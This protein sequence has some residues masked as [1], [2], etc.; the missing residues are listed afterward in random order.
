MKNFLVKIIGV[1][2]VLITLTAC[3]GGG[4]VNMVKTGTFNDYQG[5]TVGDAFDNW[6]MCENTYWTEFQTENGR[7]IV[8]YEC[9]AKKQSYTGLINIY[10]MSDHGELR[11]TVCFPVVIQG[12][13]CNFTVDRALKVL[14]DGITYRVQ[15][16]VNLDDTF[17]VSY[18]G[19]SSPKVGEIDMA[20]SGLLN[21]EEFLDYVMYN[22]ESLNDTTPG[23]AVDLVS[24]NIAQLGDMELLNL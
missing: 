6:S 21:V 11:D 1:M 19:A 9:E 3:G 23:G 17:E 22:D 24:S 7:N 8:E 2:L 18:L 12:L 4:N 14:K 10:E 16:Q 5:T 15:F 20:N 13:D